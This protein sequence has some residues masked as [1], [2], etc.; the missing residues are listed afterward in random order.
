MSARADRAFLPTLRRLDG[1][2]GLPLPERVS[3]LRELES[4]L[5]ELTRSF[6]ARGH[7]PDDARTM[8]LEAL[9]PDGAALGELRRVHASTYERLTRPLA[10]ARLR[11]VERTALV[12]CTVGVMLLEAL[13]LVG[14]D[15]GSDP[16][17]FF[18]PVL[19]LSGLLFAAIATK[20]FSLWVRR[21]HGGAHGGVAIILVLSGLV[22]AVGFGGAL[23]DLYLLAG[24]LEGTPPAEVTSLVFQ[25]LRRDAALVSVA[26]LASM[27]GGLTWFVLTQWLSALDAARAEAL[28]LRQPDIK[29][30][31]ARS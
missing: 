3:V 31:G 19:A 2:L 14:A 4:D 9:V 21:D 13:A 29:T 22:L 15:L 28:G 16:S 8:A 27:A 24:L 12:V 17:P 6:V 11:V 1:E 7:A 30:Q 23:V 5:E 10:G 20:G 25:G 18:W 26:M